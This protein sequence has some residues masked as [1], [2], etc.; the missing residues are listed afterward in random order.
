MWLTNV[1]FLSS[2][3]AQDQ[4]T[5]TIMMCGWQNITSAH[6]LVT[7][8]RFVGCSGPPMVDTWPVEATTTWCVYGLVHSR[9]QS[10]AGVNIKEL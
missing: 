6:S 9:S 7:P 5:S 4:D 3:V 8:R 1:M 10:A 2:L